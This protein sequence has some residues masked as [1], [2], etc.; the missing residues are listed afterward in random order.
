MKTSSHLHPGRG[1]WARPLP[2]PIQTGDLSTLAPWIRRRGEL[3]AT[4]RQPRAEAESL[5]P[6]ARWR[7]PRSRPYLL[8]LHH[9]LVP[10]AMN[11]GY[12][13]LPLRVITRIKW[14][15]I[16]N[17]PRTGPGIL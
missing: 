11:R 1:S 7:G 16:Y 12:Y 14:A 3:L 13:N 2:L 17:E 6:R 4:R 9:G 10:S 8:S 15:N 5:G